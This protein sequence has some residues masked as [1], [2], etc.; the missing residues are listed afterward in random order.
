M[1]ATT[2]ERPLCADESA[3]RDEP[4]TATA[5]RVEHW[6]LVEYGGYW[7]HEPLDAAVFAGGLRSH[8]EAQLARLPRSR[9]LLVKRLGPEGRLR[10]DRVRVTYG[11]TRER[12][13]RLFWLE[14]DA[15]PDLLDLDVAAALLD[16]A[17]HPGEPLEDPLLLVCTH[18]TRDRCCARY[19]QALFR[20]AHRA[21]PGW[22]WQAS[23]LGGD[24]FAGN[25]LA[26]P[27]GLCFG[28]VSPAAFAALLR[29]YLAGRIELESYRGTSCYPMDVQA[30]ELAVRRA[31]G[32]TGFYDL[33]FAGREGGR[34]RLLAE[35]SGDLHEVE[36][37]ERRS[38]TDALLTCKAER[39][40]RTRH[41][42]ARSQRVVS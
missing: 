14:L 18:G 1:T 40:R 29:D 24:R 10:R 17:P 26:L 30:A 7:P 5:S 19:G 22:S 13:R 12:E 33:R 36:V 31:T 16:G 41:F 38:E 27:E 15:H 4:L 25:L 11:Y 20:A 8:L 35:V 23:H 3:R 39:P 2:S 42:V 28:R 21:E 34:V 37:V 9:L 32:L 6:L